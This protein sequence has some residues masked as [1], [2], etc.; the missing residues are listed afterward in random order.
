MI[1]VSMW[2]RGDENLGCEMLKVG[3]YVHIRMIANR[4]VDGNEEFMIPQNAILKQSLI[5]YNISANSPR[6]LLL[7]RIHASKSTNIL[8]SSPPRHSTIYIQAKHPALTNA[9]F[10]I[11]TPTTHQNL[12]TSQ[13]P[14]CLISHPLTPNSPIA[15]TALSPHPLTPTIGPLPTLYNQCNLSTAPNIL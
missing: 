14:A 12:P 4:L 10:P 13:A 15:S 5:S 8:L 9:A 2:R 11:P 6:S 1:D 7:G 3:L